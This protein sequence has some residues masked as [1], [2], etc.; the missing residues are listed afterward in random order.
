[1]KV[2][3]VLAPYDSGHY[4]SGFGSGPDA[5][6]AGGLVEAL[7]AEGHDVNVEDTG[8]VGDQQ[9]REIATGF[10]VCR[11]VA[12]KVKLACDDGRFPIVL[13]G[14][15]FSANGAIAG[16]SADS[17]VWFDQHGDIN[18]PETSEFGFLDGMALA[19]VIGLCWRPMT[20]LIP[21]FQAIAA[22]NCILVDARDL[23]P[24]E[25]KLLAELP[26]LHTT[27]SDV[28]SQAKRLIGSGVT[29]THLHLDLDVH[30]PLSLRVNR[31]A[32]PGGPDV[33]LVRNSVCD[34]AEVLPI[35]GMTIS[36]YD[37]TFDDKAAVPEA[38]RK[39]LIELLPV[40]RSAT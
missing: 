25:E 24:S 3:I 17:I 29:R 34:L 28:A 15:C 14:N 36:A 19:S 22:E 6:L 18:T 4:R 23:D 9:E 21:G 11:A 33:G 38:V 35:S 31:Y 13:A 39:L 7:S 10:A 30:D 1:M 40:L 12:S 26:V 5:I 37:P 32:T 2:T 27:C 8:R 20:A 16:E